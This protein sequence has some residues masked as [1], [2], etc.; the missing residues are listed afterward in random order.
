MKSKNLFDVKNKIEKLEEYKY[1]YLD[2]YIPIKNYRKYEDNHWCT[3]QPQTKAYLYD[4]NKI[5][6]KEG[7]LQDFINSI[8]SEIPIG[9]FI[10]V[11]VNA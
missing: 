1:N 9:Y 3:N 7:L 5:F 10:R 2:T 4:E 8:E 11:K 6:V